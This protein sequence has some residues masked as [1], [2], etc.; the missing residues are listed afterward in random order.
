MFLLLF[1]FSR[2]PDVSVSVFVVSHLFSSA[3]NFSQHGLSPLSCDRID[4]SMHLQLSWTT[5]NSVQ[6]QEGDLLLL[7]VPFPRNVVDYSVALKAFGFANIP[8]PANCSVTVTTGHAHNFGDD[9]CSL[10][11]CFYCEP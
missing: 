3:W 11:A 8:Y 9:C 2:V 6:Q 10:M 4:P 7:S 5:A 1:L